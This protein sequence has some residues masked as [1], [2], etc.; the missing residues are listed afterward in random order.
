[1]TTSVWT[2]PPADEAGLTDWLRDRE[3]VQRDPGGAWH[4]FGYHEVK[5][6]LHN[7]GAFSNNVVKPVR[8]DSPMRLYGTG[9]LTWMDP[10]RHRQLRGLVNQV[11][12]AR[13]IAGLEPMIRETA[14]TLLDGIRGRTEVSYV[15]EFASPVVAT[16]IARMLGIPEKG[17]RLFQEWS[18]DL[19][20]LCDPSAEQ[21]SL[22]KIFTR[23]QIAEAFLHRFISR[24]RAAPAD[25]LTSGLIAAEVDG[26]R[27]GDDEIAGLMALLMSTG[28]AATMT[29]TNAIFLLA[30]HP[31]SLAKLRA[32]PELLDSAIEEIMR[33]RSQTTRVDR[34]T[35]RDVVVAGHEIP[36]GQT[37]AVWFASANR[38]PR[39]FADPEVFDIERSPNPHIAFGHGIHFCLG[40]PLGRM[41]IRIALRRLLESTVDFTVDPAGTRMLDPR[42][43]YGASEAAVRFD[44]RTA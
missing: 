15:D 42:L 40:A 27:L 2:P 44:W 9:N 8:D 36:A 3:P 20:E 31:E 34:K 5:E 16:V 1:M 14:E 23:T 4:V 41:E 7:H 28:Q 35:T 12:T 26:E 10:P 33:Y 25:D 21:N 37:V 43:M 24:R 32:R 18:K 19:L 30:R 13:Y 17:L 6:V 38:D 39:V 29:L 11:F 22:Q